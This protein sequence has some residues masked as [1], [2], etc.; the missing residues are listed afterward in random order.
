VTCRTPAKIICILSFS[1]STSK[2]QLYTTTKYDQTKAEHKRGICHSCG[3]CSNQ[4]SEIELFFDSRVSYHD[5]DY[6][7]VL[8]S[9]PPRRDSYHLTQEQRQSRVCRYISLQ[10]SRL[11]HPLSSTL[12]TIRPNPEAN[13]KDHPG[14][15]QHRRTNKPVPPLRPRALE[16]IG[17]G[18]SQ[19]EL[20]SN[21]RESAEPGAGQ[22]A[23]SFEHDHSAVFP[24]PGETLELSGG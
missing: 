22:S 9:S 10:C 16:D 5:P 6:R 14:K 13:A 4:K 18:H 7:G 2:R 15:R 1:L 24:E 17:A 19:S 11:R 21:C 12:P 8:R 3:R 23:A 20:E